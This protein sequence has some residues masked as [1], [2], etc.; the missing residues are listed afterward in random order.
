MNI[1]R[2]KKN[3]LY[4]NSNISG[5]SQVVQKVILS[6]SKRN[7]AAPKRSALSV[8]LPVI[9]QS[10]ASHSVAATGHVDDEEATFIQDYVKDIPDL[11]RTKASL[12]KLREVLY[13]SKSGYELLQY[14]S[15]SQDNGGTIVAEAGKDSMAINSSSITSLTSDEN[16]RS[17]L[18]Y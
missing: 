12:I 11:E 10:M 9:A 16:G 4:S 1:E 2:P 13:A 14:N 8:S 17:P 5:N 7:T 6:S 18:Q 3:A 15:A